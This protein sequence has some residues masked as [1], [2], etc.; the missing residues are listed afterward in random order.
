[1]ASE[2]DHSAF[3]LPFSIARKGYDQTEV[4]RHFERLDAEIRLTATDRDAAATQA[5]ELAN[6][7]ED[8]RDE[9]DKLRRDVDRLSVPPTTAEGMSER[10][11]RMLRLASDEAS[12]VRAKAEAEAAEMVSVAEQESERLRGLYESKVA[13]LDERR[14]THERE[15]ERT[16][17]T[18]QAEA[19]RIVEVAQT[20]ADRLTAEG[21]AKRAQVQ[22]D[23]EVTM[24]ERRTKANEEAEA[25]ERSSKAEANRR[26][27]DARQEA[28]SLESSSKA[29]AHRRLSEASQEAERRLRVATE[30]AERKIVHAKELAEELRV[31][32]SRVLAQLLGIRG[33]LDSVPAMLASVNREADLL[34]SAVTPAGADDRGSDATNTPGESGEEEVTAHA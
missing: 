8:A 22:Q 12:E 21:E 9:I 16:M 2:Y 32:R 19:K 7:L 34:G 24:A 10:I 26:L 25:L 3:Q 4:R 20:E 27:S 23:F 30:Q 11:S 5:R 1:M 17:Q 29:E 28:E 15:H 33:Q 31:L 14:V 13:D 6:Q 18:A